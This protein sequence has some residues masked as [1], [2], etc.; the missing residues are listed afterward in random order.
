MNIKD[1]P[2]IIGNFNQLTYLRNLVN[3]FHFFYP[4]NPIIIIDNGSTF[5]PLL[6]YYRKM[7]YAIIFLCSKND[8]VQNLTDYLIQRNDEYFIISDPDISIPF[9]TYPKF[10]EVFKGIIDSGVHHCG[11]GLKTDIPD[12][13][14]K[15]AWIAGDEKALY[16]SPVDFEYDGNVFR[17]YKAPIDTTFA[18]YAKHNGGW[19]APMK[20][21]D[22]SNSVRIFWAEHLTWYLHPQ[23]VPAEM[24]NYFASCLGR[25]DSKPSAGRNH[26]KP[27]PA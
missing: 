10:L 14:K 1:I 12:W 20:G 11:F 19:S 9:N 17:G 24:Q 15:A 7:D 18:M 16:N 3:Q 27:E 4:E 5:E 21:E 25:D 26:F 2:L 22:W 23:H 6:E 8:F 13:N